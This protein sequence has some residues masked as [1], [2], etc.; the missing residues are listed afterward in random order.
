MLLFTLTAACT[1]AAPDTPSGISPEVYHRLDRRVG[2]LLDYYNQDQFR[3][4]Y[5]DK[6]LN[7]PL[8]KLITP[9]GQ[10]A[11]YAD[12]KKQWGK[13]LGRQLRLRE[14]AFNGAVGQLIYDA[15]MEKGPVRLRCDFYQHGDD[16]T[17]GLVNMDPP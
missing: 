8:S 3:Q 17:L 11:Y 14:S 1:W 13:C 5:Q 6:S 10:F 4:I 12:L 15:R 2:K 16:Y 9:Q 7:V